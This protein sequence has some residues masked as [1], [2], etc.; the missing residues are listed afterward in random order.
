MSKEE[1][2]NKLKENSI[3]P[4][5]RI[6]K[7]FTKKS[8]SKKV[9][10]SLISLFIA[11]SMTG[12]IKDNNTNSIFTDSA[13]F[14]IYDDYGYT[15]SELEDFGIDRLDKLLD[16]NN[17]N[18][19][20]KENRL[21]EYNNT[22]DQYSMIEGLDESYVLSF[23]AV[24]SKESTEEFV[25]GLGYDSLNDY[26][27]KHHYLKEDGKTNMRKWYRENTVNLAKLKNEEDS[28]KGMNK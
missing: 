19:Y 21:R 7:R 24:S 4:E 15:D 11:I 16:D 6:Q 2:F 26:L 25:K 12:C 20:T 17:L 10:L 18:N 5:K 13:Y 23:Y 28:T 22:H 14:S 1:L 8:I 9:F 27:E 3:G